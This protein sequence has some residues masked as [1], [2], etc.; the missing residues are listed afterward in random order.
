M[1]YDIV[2]NL[3]EDEILELYND[4]VENGSELNASDYIEIRC[5]N[6]ITGYVYEVGKY[7]APG[8]RKFRYVENSCG[9]ESNFK[10]VVCRICGLGVEA[11][12]YY[13]SNSPNPNFSTECEEAG[14]TVIV[15]DEING[16][17]CRIPEK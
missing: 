17:V 16:Y 13:I 3:S 14:G 12:A 10:F 6:G 2:E 1:N 9:T 4:I 11:D 7:Y 5:S 15:S 8:S